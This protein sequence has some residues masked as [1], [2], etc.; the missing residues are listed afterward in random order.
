[1]RISLICLA[2]WGLA[3][4]LVFAGQA[5]FAGDESW[6]EQS[7]LN[8]YLEEG[9]RA[10][11]GLQAAFARFDAALDKVP[12]ARAWPDPRLSFGVFT[13]PVETRTGPQR[14]RY[15]VAQ[16][17]PWFG[18]RDLKATVAEREAAALLAQAQGVKLA[19]FREIEAA[20]FE[21]AYLGKALESVREELEILKYFEALVETRYTVSTATYADF[22]RVQVERAK[23]EERIASLN[24]YRLPLSERLRTLLGR[25]AGEVLPMP[26]GVP[27]MD[28]GWD[29]KQITA[30]VTEHNLALT[31]LDAKAEA[32]DA[33][34]VLARKEFIPDLTV[35]VESIYTDAPRMA[36]VVNEGK[37]PVA[38]TFGIN[39]PF[40]QE[41]RAA[42]VRQAKNSARATRLER[43]DKVAGLEAQTSRLL[44]GVRDGSRRLGLLLDTIV[45][46][47]RQ[48]LEASMDAYQAGKASMLD[49]LTAE[50]TLIELGLQYHRV[51][52]DQAVRLADLDMLAGEEIPRK[53]VQAPAT[54]GKE[55]ARDLR[56]SLT[57]PKASK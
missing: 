33:A 12:Q 21:Y 42:A 2:M 18:K 41:A 54:A 26:V 51:L 14:M 37:D 27:L 19:L 45:P 3:A 34:A 52:A 56:V 57:T 30:A 31:A 17:L 36:G 47:A 28:T 44:F 25:P 23:A 20:Y 5:A 8:G 10:N 6:P 16:M 39:L 49:L 53:F 9:A 15:G 24:D 7:V 22:T 43:A 55:Q 32:A 40:D 35:G 1:M 50:K 29:D 46:K 38:I 48:N 4:V 11:P 13:V